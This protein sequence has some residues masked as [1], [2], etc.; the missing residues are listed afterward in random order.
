M[1]P[2][3]A[4]SLVALFLVLA[5]G[6][7][8]HAYGQAGGLTLEPYV[9][10]KRTTRP[11]DLTREFVQKAPAFLLEYGGKRVSPTMPGFIYHGERVEGDRLL[12]ENRHRGVRGWVPLS[13]VVPVSEAEAYFSQE[14]RREPTDSFVFLMRGLARFERDDVSSAL[15]DLNE[16]L[17]LDP[18]NVAALITRAYLGRVT[19]KPANALADA[20]QAVALDPRNCY[21][22]EQRAMIFS[23]LKKDDEALRDLERAIELGSRWVMTYIG[24]GVIYLKR[25]ELQRAQVEMQ[26]ALQIDP[27]CVQAF[28]YLAAIHLKRSDPDRA[29]AAANKAVAIDPEYGEAYNARAVINRSIG[30]IN[31]ALRDLDQA[32]QIDPSDAIA[33]LNRAFFKVEL[34]DYKSAL[35]D[36][37]AAIRLDPSNAESHHGRAWILATCPDARIRNCQQAVASATRACELVNFKNPRYLSTLAI[38]YSERGDFADAVKWQGRAIDMLAANDPDRREYGKLLK[39]YQSGKPYR[40]LGLLESLRLKSPAVAAQSGSRNLE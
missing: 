22:L 38:A 28:V 36:A 25:A 37:E 12:L 11:P 33:I 5:A 30:H 20:N 4:R 3:Q 15:A 24:R 13:A 29:L 1:S 40:R 10:P 17:R 18:K 27:N 32:I 9:K 26:R 14:I 8:G 2:I 31:Q 21:V 16:A 7:C 19:Q 35:A 34:G 6:T 23:S 39:R